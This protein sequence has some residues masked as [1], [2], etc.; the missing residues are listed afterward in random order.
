VRTDQ[1]K[2]W[3][4]ATE[5]TQSEVLNR[6][7]T[8]SGEWEHSFNQLDHLWRLRQ[9]LLEAHPAEVKHLLRTKA[10]IH[11]LPNSCMSDLDLASPV[12]TLASIGEPITLRV[13]A[14]FYHGKVS[15]NTLNLVYFSSRLPAF[16]YFDFMFFLW[17]RSMIGSGKSS[18]EKLQHC[19]FEFGQC[20]IW[21]VA[22]D[23]YFI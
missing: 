13:T 12:L 23:P 3:N 10:L 19:R 7:R 6:L 17:T 18:Q 11:H 15:G 1:K 8:I 20:C 9:G 14:P 2:W 21:S 4:H 5:L 22:F 16:S